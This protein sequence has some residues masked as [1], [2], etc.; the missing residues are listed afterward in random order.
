MTALASSSRGEPCGGPQE[1]RIVF[2]RVESRHE[3]NQ[4]LVVRHAE[5]PAH[6]FS[7]DLVG[8]ELLGIDA[9]RDYGQ[10]V[11]REAQR[12]V[13]PTRIGPITM[14]NVVSEEVFATAV[15]IS[16]RTNM[17]RR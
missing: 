9:V 11:R 5:F 13:P 3:P 6:G 15:R 1:S 2:H 14:I 4:H 7:S 17:E 16:G 10:G 12:S 8:L